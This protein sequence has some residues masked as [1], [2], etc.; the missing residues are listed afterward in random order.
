MEQTNAATSASQPWH[1]YEAVA[2]AFKFIDYSWI[3]DW[4][5]PRL[6]DRQQI[7]VMVT[8]VLS[9]GGHFIPYTMRIH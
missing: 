2:I 1:S 3:T 9:D 4:L 6:S 8:N 5:Q 7:N